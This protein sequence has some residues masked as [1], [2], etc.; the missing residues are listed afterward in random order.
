MRTASTTIQVVDRDG[1]P[2]ADTEVSVEQRTHA[3]GFGNIGFD[4]VPDDHDE[5]L[6]DLFLDVFNTATLPFYWGDFEPQ[7]GQPATAQLTR[8]AEWFVERGC[9]SRGTRSSGTP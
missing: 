6:D 3:F 8:A 7:R 4:F 9:G 5:R 1:E 2:V